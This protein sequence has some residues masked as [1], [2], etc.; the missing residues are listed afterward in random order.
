MRSRLKTIPVV[1]VVSTVLILAFLVAG[2]AAT[3]AL[4]GFFDAAQ[5]GIAAYLDWYYLLVVGGCLV[6]VVWLGASRFGRIRLGPPDSRPDYRYLTW[7]AMLFT[8][9][10][11]IGLVFW[12]VA[13]PL[14]HL[15]DPPM[16]EPGGA[17]AR[18][19]AM[20]FTF[21]HWGLHAW[22]I[23]IVVG[24]SL[25]YFSYR[26][27]LPLLIRSALYPLLG[28]RIHGPVG[29]AVDIFAVFGTMFGVATSLGF[30]VLQINA[31]LASLDLVRPSTTVQLLLIVVITIAATF[32]VLSGLDKGIL[33]LSV[34]NVCVGLA[35]MAFVLST[36]P[37]SDVLSS[38]VQQIGD[39]VQ[40]LPGT[41]L[42]A[43]A[44]ARTGWQAQW[45][46]FYWGW[47]ISWAPF[48]GMF[49]ARVSRGRT[50]REFVFGVLLVPAALTFL[51]L[52]VYGNTAFSLD[53]RS[54]GALS[55]KVA[56]DPATALF[57]LLSELP[58][59]QA[60]TVFAVVVVAVYFVTS[61]D[62][63]AYVINLLTSGGKSDT[64]KI[65]RVYW[66]FVEGAVAAVLLLAGSGG[67]LALQTAAVTTAL[68]FSLVMLVMCYGLVR[69]LYADD[70]QVP[71]DRITLAEPLHERVPAGESPSRSP[72]RDHVRGSP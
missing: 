15:A 30:G 58:L 72:F 46:I 10:M 35:L 36:G 56:D 61:S 44:E 2:V 19:E 21:F 31:G 66:S 14:S 23:Y 52:A 38:F 24:L 6:F 57:G 62:S 40:T 1:F 8:A 51:W 27:R 17:A 67:L 49:I 71:L 70:R 25:G 11:G 4:H 63:A 42:W 41:T 16:A 48:V 20:R 5:E 32:S 50:I 34:V 54:D 65:Q 60:T 47:W 9:G 13:E 28:K 59:S 3:D 43:D 29:H 18:R 55:A 26:H 22:A 68:P 39:Y 37:T 45:T 64:P 12:S 69:A 33:R 53:A 7:F